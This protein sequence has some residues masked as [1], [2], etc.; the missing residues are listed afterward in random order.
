MQ[1]YKTKTRKLPGTHWWQVDKNAFRLYHE[2]RK[3]TKRRPYVRSAYFDKEKIFLELFWHHLRE[4]TNIRYKTRRAKYF[5]CAIELMQKTRFKPTSKPNPN[6][7]GETLHRFMGITPDHEVFYLQ[8]KEDKK[9]QKWFM[10]VF[11]A[12]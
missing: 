2:I 7:A 1:A 3:K 4:K 11:P 6:N 8:I 9:K 12:E 5:P 10:S